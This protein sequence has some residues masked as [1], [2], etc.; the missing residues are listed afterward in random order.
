MDLEETKRVLQGRWMDHPLHPLV[1]T[2]P[3]GLWTASAAFDILSLITGK[4]RFRKVADATMAAGLAGAAVAASTGLA[5]FADMDPSPG[6]QHA[7]IHGIGNG[8]LT[9]LYGVNWALRRTC[10]GSRRAP[11]W[12]FLLSLAGIGGLTFTGWLGGH[13][14]YRHGVG[15][16]TEHTQ[17]HAQEPRAA[18]QTREREM[19][20]A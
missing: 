10:D 12:P 13:M 19:V 20:H 18:E 7:T 2:F 1:V 3:L 5:E 8:L 15:V 17:E 4:P 9:G 11:F 6:R 14:V 16:D